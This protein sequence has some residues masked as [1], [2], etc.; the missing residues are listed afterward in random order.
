MLSHSCIMQDL[1]C[2][3][4]ISCYDA[5]TDSSCRPLAPEHACSLVVAHGLFC[6]KDSWM[7]PNQGL[8][9]RPLHCKADSYPL[10]HQGSPR[11]FN[12]LIRT[13]FTSCA[14][15]FLLIS[16]LTPKS[17]LFPCSFVSRFL[18]YIMYVVCYFS[19]DYS[20]EHHTY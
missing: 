11:I 10:D 3:S 8:N 2:I 1:T 13:C 7:F 14:W 18:N 20:S 5:Q 19:S 16:C 4:G 15:L 17:M 9:P 6:S 12:F